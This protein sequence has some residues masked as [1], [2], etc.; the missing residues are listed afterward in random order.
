MNE[1]LVFRESDHKY[2]WNGNL[3]PSVTQ[4]LSDTGLWPDYSQLDPFYADRGNKVHRAISLWEK[5][6]LREDLLSAQLW[7]YLE[8]YKLWKIMIG[9]V[10]ISIETPSYNPTFNY[11]GTADSYGDSEFWGRDIFV[12]IK[13]GPPNI[14]FGLQLAGY[15]LMKEDYYRY[16]RVSVHLQKDGSIANHQVH[17]NQED[18]QIFKS[19]VTVYHA[20]R[21]F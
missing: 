1:S 19:A 5:W 4:I 15:A 17:D 12:D 21:R 14:F 16:K 8:S 6:R 13:C 2:F 11:A 7:P 18:F 10:P 9:Y 3:V 20:K